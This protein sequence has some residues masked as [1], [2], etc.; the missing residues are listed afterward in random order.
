MVLCVG[1]LPTLN[2]V[3]KELIESRKVCS[4]QE[5]VGASAVGVDGHRQFI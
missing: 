2:H 3:A 4:G 5:S 1:F